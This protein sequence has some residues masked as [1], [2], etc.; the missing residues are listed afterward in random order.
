MA[1][2]V[3]DNRLEAEAE[4]VDC[5]DSIDHRDRL[6]SCNSLKTTKTPLSWGG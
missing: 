2:L 1:M 6:R 3:L 5:Q 4:A